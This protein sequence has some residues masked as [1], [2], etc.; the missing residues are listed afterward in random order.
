LTKKA[1]NGKFIS[2]KREIEGRLQAMPA[3]KS[4]N[5]VIVVEGAI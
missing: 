1:E 5:N 3:D 4:R 2:M